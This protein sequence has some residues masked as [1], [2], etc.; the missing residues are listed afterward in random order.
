M[1]LKTTL[2]LHGACSPEPL[3]LYGEHIRSLRERLGDDVW[4]LIC[5]AVVR[6]RSEEFGRIRRRLQAGYGS[7]SSAPLGHLRLTA[8]VLGMLPSSKQ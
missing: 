2:L 5:Q 3:D 7:P 1:A 8:A 6:M 4:F